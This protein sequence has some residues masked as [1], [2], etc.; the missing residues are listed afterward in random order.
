[1]TIFLLSGGLTVTRIPVLNNKTIM[2]PMS[3]F[4]SSNFYVLEATPFS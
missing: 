2:N 4:T 3:L 1:M